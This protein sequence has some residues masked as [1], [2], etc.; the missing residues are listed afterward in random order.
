[1]GNAGVNAKV[2][3]I[4]S[5]GKLRFDLTSCGAQPVD[6]LEVLLIYRLHLYAKRAFS[7]CAG[8]QLILLELGRSEHDWH[9]I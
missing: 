9:A 5:T 7:R 8:Q 6:I 2:T 1:M 3:G 4:R